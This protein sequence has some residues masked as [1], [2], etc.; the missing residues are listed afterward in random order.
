[1]DTTE[2]IVVDARRPLMR[3]SAVFA[4]LVL[5]IA[6]YSLLLLLGSAL[7]LSIVDATDAAAVG[8]GFGIGAGLWMLLSSVVAFFFG[9]LLAARLDGN[10]EHGI[11]ALHGI[12]LW[13][14]ATVLLAYLATAGILG[15]AQMAG[16]AVQSAAS[17]AVGGG[18][19]AGAMSGED[20]AAGNRIA[21]M[22]K[23]KIAEQLSQAQ[24]PA[25]QPGA[26][27]TGAQASPQEIRQA[28]DQL[29]PEVLTDVGM[30]L[31]R[32]DVEGA[33]ST[34]A[35][36]TSL[37]RAQIDSVVNGV[38][39]ETEQAVNAAKAK[40]AET[41]EQVAKYGQAVLWSVFISSALGLIAAVIGGWAGPRTFV[42]QPYAT[43]IP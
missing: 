28:V 27:A 12:T 11:G 41:S 2:K 37:S 14:A 24:A 43:A 13:S 34:L 29:E 25:G 8:E 1:M 32:G 39:A 31:M 40:V 18:A 22:V 19:I 7:G 20:S 35:I 21:A 4:G 17:A 3:W 5:V 42:R 15:T 38:S 23:I 30:A 10:P 33:K 16:S 26:P 9:G 36:N 6:A